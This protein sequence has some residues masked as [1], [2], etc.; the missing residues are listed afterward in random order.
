MLLLITTRMGANESKEL[1]HFR[2]FFGVLGKSCVKYKIYK[3]V[4][5]SKCHGSECTVDIKILR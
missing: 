2:P 4:I 5:I 3:K 1:T